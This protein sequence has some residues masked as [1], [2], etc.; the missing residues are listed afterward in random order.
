MMVGGNL[1]WPC[2]NGCTIYKFLPFVR[3]SVKC[4]PIALLSPGLAAVHG[5]GLAEGGIA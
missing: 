4:S 3:L 5:Q 1:R 2:A